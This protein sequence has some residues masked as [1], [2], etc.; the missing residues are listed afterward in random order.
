MVGAP[1][2]FFPSCCCARW[3]EGGEGILGQSLSI[4]SQL[5]RGV[6][7]ARGPRLPPEPFNS[8]PVAAGRRD[9]S[10]QVQV[11]TMLSILS[12][13]LRCDSRGGGHGSHG[14]FNSFPVAANY[15]VVEMYAVLKPVFQFFPSCCGA[16]YREPRVRQ[17]T[18]FNSF[19]VAAQQCSLR[20][21]LAPQCYP[22]NSFPVAARLV[23]RFA[24]GA[25]ITFN[26]FPVAAESYPWLPYPPTWS[27]S[28]Q[29]F[30][31]CCQR[32]RV[33]AVVHQNRPRPFNSFPVAAR[34]RRP[35]GTG[36]ASSLSILSQLL[37]MMLKPREWS[38]NKMS[39][40]FFPS[41]CHRR[42][43]SETRIPVIVSFNSF[44]VAA[45]VFDGWRAL[46]SVSS[47]NSFPVA[48][49][50]FVSWLLIS[51]SSC[52]Q[53]LAKLPRTPSRRMRGFWPSRRVNSQIPA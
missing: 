35:R 2:Q 18:A 8:F 38:T 4:L 36:C 1:F 45:S 27:G 22:F 20:G 51:F 28:F 50:G 12:Q 37:Q 5:L 17:A 29:F 14:P 48:A 53:K 23:G 41:C 7:R 33:A 11:P 19:P 39:F 16:A 26:S 25:A 13:L 30:P 24:R 9:R 47:F 46:G 6:G 32:G 15:I 3:G 44:P 52:R 31:S 43:V 42:R 49:V 34:T 10:P 21:A 40:Q